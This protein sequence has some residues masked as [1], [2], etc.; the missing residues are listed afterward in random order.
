MKLLQY[1][2]TVL[3]LSLMTS[4]VHAERPV[5]SLPSSDAASE[6]T[7]V[8]NVERIHSQEATESGVPVSA[9]GIVI[10]EEV[11]SPINPYF[12]YAYDYFHNTMGGIQ[13]GGAGMGLLDLGVEFDLEALLGIERSILVVSA[14]A[15][16]GSDFSANYVGDLG[17]VSNI[18]SDTNFNIFHFFVEKG[19]G[20]G[21]SFLRVGQFG[22]DDDFMLAATAELFIS[23][24]FV[25][26]NTQSGNIPSP[27]FPF[28]APGAVVNYSPTGEWY[29]RT[30]I[31]AGDAG[32]GGPNSRGFEWELGGEAGYAVFSEAGYQ[33]SEAGGIAS[34]G[35]YYHTGEFEN[36]RTGESEEGVGAFYAMV[37]H[38]LTPNAEGDP[39]LSIFARG[40]IA[41]AEEKVAIR[42]QV[43]G[44]I[45]RRE[46]F[47]PGDALGLAVSH[48]TLGHD[49]LIANPESTKAETVLE[50]TYLFQVTDH[51]AV[52]PDIQ[53]IFDPVDSGRDALVFGIR[54][55]IE[56]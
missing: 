13:T 51:F 45:V 40:S 4:L 12:V 27:I 19:F 8:A 20:D 50:A 44:G 23:S 17:V 6:V 1:T 56:F 28:A 22:I 39:K 37:D 52:Q 41:G 29:F 24:P 46:A 25:P 53:Y 47:L 18:S 30:G 43:D 14:F 11:D 2:T 3:S 31:Y 34:I 26:F 54:G 49:F 33:Y 48:T 42:S 10:E 35:G 32:P 38:P 36:F 16:Q 21:D 55:V 7:G 9:K 5:H 15:G